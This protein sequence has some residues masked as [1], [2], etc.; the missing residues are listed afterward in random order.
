MSTSLVETNFVRF[1]KYVASMFRSFF[2]LSLSLEEEEEEE[3]EESCLEQLTQFDHFLLRFSPR[4]FLELIARK[5]PSNG[6][7]RVERSLRVV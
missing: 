4:I 5:I 2:S 1:A 6:R 3:E 7:K